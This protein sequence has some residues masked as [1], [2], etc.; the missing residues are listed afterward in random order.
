MSFI[1]LSLCCFL[2]NIEL[3]EPLE[4]IFPLGVCNS[5]LLNIFAILPEYTGLYCYQ[6]AV[7]NGENEFASTIHFMHPEVDRGDIVVEKRFPIENV[8][9]GLSIYQKSL[10]FGALA[11]QEILS[12][13]ISNFDLPRQPQ[14]NGIRNTYTRAKPYKIEI[15]WD[16]SSDGI[17]N[18]IRASNFYPLRPPAFQMCFEGSP[19]HKAVCLKDKTD[20]QAGTVL[21]FDEG[22]IRVASGDQYLI[23]ITLDGCA[24]PE[25][26]RGGRMS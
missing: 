25:R 4:K 13:I 3:I 26:K 1:R 21:N 20:K 24:A 7:F 19:V 11:I 18:S 9:T 5:H 15:N 14:K 22:K 10:K 2:F 16:Q 17:M 23:E 8:D 6:Y 12:K